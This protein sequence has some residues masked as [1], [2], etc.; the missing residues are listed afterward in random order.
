MA[1]KKTET[2]T[3]TAK[4]QARSKDKPVRGHK[5]RMAESADIH[6]LY[7]DSVQCVEAE[8]DF[9]D[10]TFAALRG[11]HAVSLREDFCGT[12][13]TSCEWVRRRRGN[14][15]IGVDLN[16]EVLDWGLQNHVAALKPATRKR[17]SFIRADVMKVE[18]D[19]VDAVLAMNF[20]YWLFM[21]RATL[22]R[23]F[24]RVRS[25]LVSDGILFLDAY[26]GYEAPKV[27]KER[28]K[29]DGFTYIWD[30][31]SFNPVDGR[32]QCY[33]HFKFPD[34]SQIKRAFSYAWRLW[35][36]PE[37]TEVLSEAGFS[38]VTVYGEG[39]DEET[40]EGDGQYSPTTQIDADP[41]YITYIVAEK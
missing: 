11:R 6:V 32:M 24:R 12:G 19:P 10:V 41:S 7:E 1:N 39:T 36:L 23:Y 5:P 2:K 27:C 30:Q 9:V 21:E 38:K 26:G 20:S 40:G 37:I 34:G 17:V 16:A 35:T 31:A 3:K 22:R 33:I 25:A 8:I 28:T 4:K 29:H 15:A 14:R 13:N 18:T